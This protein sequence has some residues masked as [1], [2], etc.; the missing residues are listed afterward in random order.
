MLSGLPARGAPPQL[1]E[2]FYLE[3]TEFDHSFMGGSVSL[4]QTI[5]TDPGKMRNKMVTDGLLV[6]GHLEQIVR[7]D[8]HNLGASEHQQDRPEGSPVSQRHKVLFSLSTKVLGFP[9][10]HIV[11]GTVTPSNS[12]GSKSFNKYE[13]WIDSE[14]YNLFVDDRDHPLWRKSLYLAPSYH[15]G[16]RIPNLFQGHR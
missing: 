14:K 11:Y 9:F 1:P 7:C 12:K 16:L 4:K 13:Y 6:N 15:C 5:A 10:K 3:S 2:S 8:L